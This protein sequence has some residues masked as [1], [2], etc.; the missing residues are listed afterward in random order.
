MKNWLFSLLLCIVSVHAFAAEATKIKLAAGNWPPF[1]SPSADEQVATDLVSL[2]LRKAGYDVEVHAMEW[3]DAMEA[4]KA[5]E[6]DGFVMTWRTAE[7][8]AFLKYS[9]PY[10]ENR[11]LAVSLM[12]RGFSINSL[13]DLADKTIGK[14]EGYGYGEALDGLKGKGI[15][16]SENEGESLNKLLAG[17]VDVIII[18]DLSLRYRVRALTPEQ[19]AQLHVHPAELAVLPS[20]MT[21]RKD[22]EGADEILAGFNKAISG[23]VADGTYNEVLKLPW[24]IADTDRDG[25]SEMVTHGRGLDLTV[26]PQ[27]GEYQLFKE[28][29]AVDF[30]NRRVYRVGNQQFDNWDDARKAIIDQGQTREGD[31]MIQEN[32]Y[33]IGVPLD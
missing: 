30:A 16:Y 24:I 31:R 12:S 15:V 26:P 10:I 11:M 9:D 2:A 25:V 17:D 4:V 19:Q 14:G 6:Y 20:H 1:T 23:M 5:G 29:P 13:A 22:M 32:T 27:E 28:E 8:E 7:R 18:D 21:L 3:H 33:Q